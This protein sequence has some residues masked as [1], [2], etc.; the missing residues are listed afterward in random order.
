MAKHTV[1]GQAT[2]DERKLIWP[3]NDH[4]AEAHGPLAVRALVLLVFIKSRL[5]WGLVVLTFASAGLISTGSIERI[6]QW[7]VE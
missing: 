3:V 1:E 7:Y 2:R 5:A 4:I 6:L